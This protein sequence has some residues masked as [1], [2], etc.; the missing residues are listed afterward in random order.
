MNPKEF[1]L[2]EYISKVCDCKYPTREQIRHIITISKNIGVNNKHNLR[3]IQ[4]FLEEY[5]CYPWK[6]ISGK[7]RKREIVDIRHIYRKMAFELT[8]RSLI[9]I[10][11]S[12]LNTH[13]TVLWSIKQVDEIKELREE[14]ENYKNKFIELNNNE[15][16]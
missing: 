12:T 11:K 15:K 13:S 10:G 4:L 8:S 16:Y 3:E 2:A 7:T 9:V 1:Q 6:V 5:S 14:Y